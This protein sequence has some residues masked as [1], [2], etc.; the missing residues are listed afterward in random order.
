MT[1]HASPPRSS[2][3]ARSKPEAAAAPAAPATARQQAA[4]ALP[5]SAAV[6]ECPSCADGF[7]HQ[8]SSCLPAKPAIEAAASAAASAAR[9]APAPAAWSPASQPSRRESTGARC[10]LV[11]VASVLL[12][13]ISS[14]LCFRC[15][16]HQSAP[17]RFETYLLNLGIWN[18]RR[19]REAFTCIKYVSHS[20]RHPRDSKSQTI[21]NETLNHTKVSYVRLPRTSKNPTATCDRKCAVRTKGQFRNINSSSA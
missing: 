6:S 16:V 14:M 2:S 4:R 11:V 19:A 1:S 21:R 15:F 17:Y 10:Q 7:A 8:S 5:G 9:A 13:V 20:I 18:A 12:V 3:A